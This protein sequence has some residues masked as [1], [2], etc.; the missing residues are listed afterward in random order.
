MFDL[1][2]KFIYI[3]FSTDNIKNALDFVLLTEHAVS[4]HQASERY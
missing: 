4:M 3:T 2:M 1:D